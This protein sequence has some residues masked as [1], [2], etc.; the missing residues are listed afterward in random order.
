MAEREQLEALLI[1]T[2]GG[3]EQAFQRLYAATSS[4]L[5]ALLLRI[6]RRPERAQD[7]L[8][9]A[10]VR[11]WQKADTYSPERGAPLTWL[12]SIAR[13]RALDMLR[14]KQPEVAM[15]EEPDRVATLL[16]D[17]QALSPLE[18][19]E[20]EQSLAAINACMGR[21]S[22]EQRECVLMAYY[23]GMTHQELATR[24]DAPLGTVKSWIRR[25]LMRLRDCLSEEATS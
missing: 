1:A 13:Y 2:A 8:Q 3:D 15:P 14:R 19:N 24:M 12:L 4:Q 6:L 16:E 20:N 5:Y 25:G 11:I 9:D 21:L 18:Q 23:E 10:Y 17:E 22:D 7:A